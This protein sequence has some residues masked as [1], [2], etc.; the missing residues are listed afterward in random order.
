MYKIKL[1]INIILTIT[2]A[3]C[4]GTL[5]LKNNQ[6]AV[7]EY[8]VTCQPHIFYCYRKSDLVCHR[9]YRVML[10]SISEEIPEMFIKCN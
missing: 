8:L 5:S 1:T 9:G 7:S 2:V 4:A 3:G 10:V 6:R